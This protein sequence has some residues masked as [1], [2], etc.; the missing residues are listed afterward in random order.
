[1]DEVWKR[2]EIDSPCQKI[3]VIHE[4]AGICIGCL[5]TRA[6]I[7]GWSRMDATARADTLAALNGREGLLRGKRRG[8]RGRAPDTP[9]QL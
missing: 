5:R 3:C 9:P 7:A 4:G 8:R 1:M 2:D 6:E